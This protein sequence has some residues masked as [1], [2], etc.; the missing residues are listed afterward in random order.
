MLYL[1]VCVCIQVNTEFKRI[2]TMLRQSIFLSHLD[3]H[4]DRKIKLFGKREVIETKLKHILEEIRKA[5]IDWLTLLCPTRQSDI[6]KKVIMLE[7]EC[8][9][10]LFRRVSQWLWKL[11]SEF[12]YY[13]IFFFFISREFSRTAPCSWSAALVLQK[14]VNSSRRDHGDKMFSYKKKE[15]KKKR[16]KE[17]SICVK[18]PFLQELSTL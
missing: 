16:S 13:W 15:K 8:C 11:K 10:Q 18:N 2:A 5:S 1:C 9:F 17:Q 3:F 14:V 6:T 4:T 7:N 12:Y